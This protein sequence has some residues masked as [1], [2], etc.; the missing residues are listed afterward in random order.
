MQTQYINLRTYNKRGVMTNHNYIQ[1]LGTIYNTINYRFV[2]FTYFF[3][4]DLKVATVEQ[5]LISG[6]KEL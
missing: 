3:K 6:G 5:D 1:L 2:L 4:C